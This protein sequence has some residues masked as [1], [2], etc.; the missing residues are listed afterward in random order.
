VVAKLEGQP[1]H[2][3]DGGDVHDARRVDQV[4]GEGEAAHGHDSKAEAEEALDEGCRQQDGEVQKRI[5]Q[6]RHAGSRV[7]QSRGAA[8]AAEI[9]LDKQPVL[10]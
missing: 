10:K 4:L 5:G 1:D 7:A 3:H 9:S 8:L 2:D 6:R